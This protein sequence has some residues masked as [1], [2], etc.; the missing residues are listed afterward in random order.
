MIVL[1][2]TEAWMYFGVPIRVHIFLDMQTT[3]PR[4]IT[5]E[6][7]QKKMDYIL[8]DLESQKNSYCS[9]QVLSKIL[10]AVARE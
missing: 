8:Q 2:Q 10:T 4:E 9:K 7:S 3:P 6:K 5:R 1:Q